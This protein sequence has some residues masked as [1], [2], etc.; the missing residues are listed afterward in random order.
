VKQDC[1][2]VEDEE[3]S[4]DEVGGCGVGRVEELDDEDEER[5]LFD[6]G[7]G[8]GGVGWGGVIMRMV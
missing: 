4:G 6:V 2:E 3:G 8:E 7:G 5:L 1:E